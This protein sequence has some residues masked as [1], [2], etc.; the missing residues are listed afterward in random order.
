MKEF[1]EFEVEGVK[2]V[3]NGRTHLLIRIANKASQRWYVHHPN[4][5]VIGASKEI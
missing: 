2:N 4:E 1:F 5:V 3:F